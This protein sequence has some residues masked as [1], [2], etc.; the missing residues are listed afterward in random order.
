VSRRNNLERTGAPQADAP[1]PLEIEGGSDLF[2]F[3]NPTEFVELPSRGAYYPEGH[4][5]HNKAVIEIKHMTAKEEDILTSEALLRNGLAVDR[6]LES[7]II[8]NRIKVADLL[9][10]D[11]N[12]ILIATRMTGFGPFYEVNATCPSCDRKSDY[13]FNLTEL[14]TREVTLGD[15]VADEGN[16]VFS[17]DLP[18]SKVRIYVRLLT[19][20]DEDNITSLLISKDGTTASNPITGLLKAVVVGA[21]EH[22]DPA[23]V[24]KFIEMMPIPDVKHLRTTYENLK[25]DVD[26]RFDYTCPLCHEEGKV[27]M[28]LTAQF[29][30]P[31]Q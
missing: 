31:D 13:T 16:G 26:L 19:T 11:K 17:F 9:L 20:R 29:F 10:G 24:H 7:V 4:P 5:L 23:T 22:T 25:P 6:L 8:D 27:G 3:V 2:A 14:Q 30:W 15:N 21:N 18:V 1:A 28:P 12:A